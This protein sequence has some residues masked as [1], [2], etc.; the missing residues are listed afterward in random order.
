MAIWLTTALVLV[1]C[2]PSAALEA[3]YFPERAQNIDVL[4]AGWEP[5][6]RLAPDCVS[7]T[8]VRSRYVRLHAALALLALALALVVALLPQ[9]VQDAYRPTLAWLGF[10]GL[11]AAV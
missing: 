1:A 9:V 10:P 2:R 5:E 3:W 11:S 8:E 6:T 7:P 4:M